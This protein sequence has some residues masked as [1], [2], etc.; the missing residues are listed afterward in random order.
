MKT[1]D[2]NKAIDE[3]R[4]PAKKGR[5]TYTAQEKSQAQALFILGGK[6][7]AEVSKIMDIPKSTLDNWSVKGCWHVVAKNMGKTIN[8]EKADEALLNNLVGA[9]AFNTLVKDTANEMLEDIEKTA[10]EAKNLNLIQ[11]VYTNAEKR[12]NE[13]LLVEQIE[14]S[15]T[16]TIEVV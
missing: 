5:R 11:A 8:V 2:V 12:I 16:I 6:S 9:I 15:N 7:L 3:I 4:K 13:L 14:N 1:M 10:D